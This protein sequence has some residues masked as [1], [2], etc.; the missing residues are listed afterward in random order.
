MFVC[1]LSVV[2]FSGITN[3]IGC[4]FRL[5]IY[6]YGLPGMGTHITVGPAPLGWGVIVFV[7]SFFMLARRPNG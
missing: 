7:S 1:S 4:K 3:P 2:R 5:Q 6:C